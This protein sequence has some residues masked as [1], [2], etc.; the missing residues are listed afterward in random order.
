M[1][2]GVQARI[3]AQARKAW[4]VPTGLLLLIILAFGVLVSRLGFYWDDW[5]TAWFHHLQGPGLYW[6]VFASDRPVHLWHCSLPVP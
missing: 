4:S 5:P 6:R 2:I 3:R 1:D